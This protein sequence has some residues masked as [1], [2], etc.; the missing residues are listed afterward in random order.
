MAESAGLLSIEESGDLIIT[1]SHAR[2]V[3]GLWIVIDG[4]DECDQ[5]TRKD[6]FQALERIQKYG[7]VVRIFV[8]GRNEGDVEA[9]MRKYDNFIIEPQDSASDIQR[10]IREELGKLYRDPSKERLV[11]QMK[12]RENNIIEAL[13]NG[14]KGMY[15]VD[16]PRL[17][18]TMLLT[19]SIGFSRF[20]CGWRP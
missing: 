3:Q 1:L 4:L 15:V 19:H 13:M 9:Y 6:L 18:C 10:Y 8:T 17:I 12:I 11:E 7:R 16:T 20:I 5:D 2:V 14:A